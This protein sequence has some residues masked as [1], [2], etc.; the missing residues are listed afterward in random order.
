[1]VMVRLSM[2]RM[3]MMVRMRRRMVIERLK[4]GIGRSR[5][6]KAAAKNQALT[7]FTSQNG[8][9][10]RS[11]MISQSKWQIGEKSQYPTS[12]MSFAASQL[13]CS[14]SH[15]W[16]IITLS[17]FVSL[18]LD[19]CLFVLWYLSLLFSWLFVCCYLSLFGC[20]LISLFVWLFVDIVLGRMSDVQYLSTSTEKLWSPSMMPPRMNMFPP[21]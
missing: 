20:L 9:S 5:V 1:M 10:Q 2:T 18:S 16:N 7:V 3:M 21:T 11:S 17:I 8:N 19:N 4:L 14:V 13:S 6:F 12:G 15:L